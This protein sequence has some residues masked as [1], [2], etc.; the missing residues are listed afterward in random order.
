M[1]N[2]KG[3]IVIDNPTKEAPCNSPQ[4]YQPTK[5]YF[6][7]WKDFFTKLNLRDFYRI[8]YKTN[9]DRVREITVLEK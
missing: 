9:T 1:L 5:F 3:L 2:S 6:E 7:D 8:T 4:G